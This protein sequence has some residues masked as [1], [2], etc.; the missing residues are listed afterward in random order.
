MTNTVIGFFD[1]S[2]DAQEA[3]DQ[4]LQ[5]GFDKG[6]IDVTS[7]SS[8]AGRTDTS[9]DP[10]EKGNAITRFFSS[11]FGENSDDAKRYSSMGQQ[12]DSMV[13]VH[14][15]SADQ[16][17][18]AADILDACGAS[19]VDEKSAEYAKMSATPNTDQ[20]N[21]DTDRTG[22]T[23]QRIEEELQVG[24]RSVQTGGVRVRSRIVEKPVEES[25]RLRSEHVSVDR[26][27][28]DRPANEADWNN[29]SEKEIELTESAEVPV[30]SKAARV[31]EEI[32]INKEAS[33]RTETV[34]DTVRKTEVDIENINDKENKI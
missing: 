21:P 18:R 3:V 5:A 33:E 29:F 7:G 11:L 23:I 10:G 2:A 4:L 9:T 8:I 15:I 24:K 1:D 25:L 30:V 27:I 12:S 19:Y 26:K 28:V 31:V 13:T 16:S 32:R 22:D 14:T 34:K 6:N 20:I 17:E